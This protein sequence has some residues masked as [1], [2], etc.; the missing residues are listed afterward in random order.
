MASFTGGSY[1]NL[2][3]SGYGYSSAYGGIPNVPNPT[4]TAGS[5]IAGNQSNLPGAANLAA[6]VNQ[7]NEAQ[8]LGQYNMAIPNY[9]A[10]TA[11]ASGV[12]GQE[13]A[14]QLPQDVINQLTQQAAERGIATGGAGSANN[15]SA[16]LAALG[17]T[18]LGEE[19]QGFANLGQLVQQAPK[20]PFFDPSSM[21]VTPEQQQ[22]AQMAANTFAT[23]PVPRDAARAAIAAATPKNNLPWWANPSGNWLGPGTTGTPGAGYY[24]PASA[25]SMAA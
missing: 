24:T 16:Y 13:L 14:G 3:G 21:F 1:G 17:L 11:T 15:N 4:A 10:L 12:T 2:P 22:E 23:A 9:S 19:Q 6:G 18:S 5:A 7:S 20:A 25:A 8:L